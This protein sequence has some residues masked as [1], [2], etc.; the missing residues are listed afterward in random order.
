MTGGVMT[1]RGDL[2][3]GGS[4][5]AQL[6]DKDYPLG[7]SLSTLGLS[8]MDWHGDLAI[9]CNI[10]SQVPV[11]RS[12]NLIARANLNNKGA[13]QV[14]LRIN[15]SEQLQLALTSLFPLLKKLFDYFHQVQ[16]GQ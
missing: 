5:E 14:S 12:T 7:R 10:Q 9:G 16:Y 2:A 15:S 11:G 3:Y 13:G 1:G 6:R 8:I 4:L